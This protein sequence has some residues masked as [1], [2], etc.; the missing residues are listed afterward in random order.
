MLSKFPTISEMPKTPLLPHQQAAVDKLLPLRVGGLFM[1][2]GTGKSRT[3]IELAH[4]RR[5]KIDHTVIFCPVALKTTWHYELEKHLHN[6]KVYLFND[7]TQQGKIPAADWFVVGVESIGQSDRVT[8]AV[9][10]LITER[11]FVA[12]DES[13]TCKNP[14]ARRTNRIT[15]MSKG[16]RYRVILTGTPVG[17]GVE[18][19]YAQLYFLSPEILG[20]RSFYTFANN[21]LEYSDKYKGLVINHKRTDWIAAK[22]E[23]YIYQVKRDEC[24]DLPDQIYLNCFC[25][26]TWAQQQLYRQAK[27]EILMACPDEE[28]SSYTIFR[29][30]TALREIVSGFWNRYPEPSQWRLP[31]DSAIAPELLTCPHDRIDLLISVLAGIPETE[32]VIIWSNFHYS[33]QQITEC[34]THQFGSESYSEYHGKTKNRELSLATWRNHTRFLVASPKCG[35][36]GLSL[37]EATYQVFYNNDFPYRL[38]EQAESR[39]HR[40]GQSHK[41]TYID[42]VCLKGIDERIFQ[43]LQRKENLA[44]TFKRELDML[45]SKEKKLQKIMAL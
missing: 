40:I 22:I 13:D 4:L 26:M 1:E 14:R 16:C 35:G 25:E 44:K 31:Q 30:F 3:L 41:V 17:E 19:L 10:D 9:Y 39:N 34:L 6:P 2:M 5:E 23:P 37:N 43:A 15:A 12:L 28:L 36:R 8:L 7:Q 27:E 11:T 45:K 42:L 24:L 21:H 38:R 20:Y 33:T 32:K 18:D 29:L